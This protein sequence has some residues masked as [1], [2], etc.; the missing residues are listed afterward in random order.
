MFL[1]VGL[2]NPITVEMMITAGLIG[3]PGFGHQ[4]VYKSAG[5]SNRSNGILAGMH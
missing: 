5:S 3:W 1:I 2:L 4:V